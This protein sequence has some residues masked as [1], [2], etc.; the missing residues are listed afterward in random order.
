M[1]HITWNTGDFSKLEGVFLPNFAGHRFASTGRWA[2]SQYTAMMEKVETEILTRTLD[3]YPSLASVIE[4][5]YLQMDTDYSGYSP[6]F[7]D[8]SSLKYFQTG[9]RY[10][11]TIGPADIGAQYFYGNLFRPN[12]AFTAEGIDNFIDALVTSYGTNIDLDLLAPQINYS[13]Y[14]QIGA[15]YA[16]VLY[17][18]N[19]RGELAI[20]LTEDTKGDNGSVPNPFI[21]WSLGF[22]RDLIYG[23]NLNMQLN[24]TIRLLNGKIGDNPVY[25]TEADT[26]ASSTRL[27]TQVSRKFFRDNLESKATLIW[28]IENSDCYIIPAFIWSQ[29]TLSTELSA[30]FFAGKESG[31]LG[32]YRKSSFIKFALKYLF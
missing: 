3:R 12:V 10:T 31:E 16:Q 19:V 4:S 15:D 8:T 13:R 23:I 30:G 5:M 18:F 6:E 25:D 2:P 29:G 7:P 24:E 14:H 1:L 9:L 22:D 26:N 21:G 11:T 17:G 20:H 32:Q 28:D 27:T